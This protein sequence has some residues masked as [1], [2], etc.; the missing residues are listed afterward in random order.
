MANK[1]RLG[2]RTDSNFIVNCGIKVFSSSG[3]GVTSGS[4]IEGTLVDC[5]N[6]PSNYGSAVMC[7]TGK[8]IDSIQTTFD[9]P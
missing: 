9:T 7:D 6:L 2:P 5:L 1:V 8:Y 4:G 3:I